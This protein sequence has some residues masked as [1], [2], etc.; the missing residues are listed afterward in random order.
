[1]S[2][3]KFTCLSLV[4][5]LASIQGRVFAWGST[6][7]GAGLEAMVSAARWKAG[8]FRYTGAF[9]LG[10]A[11]YDSDIYF[12][13]LANPIPDYT[14][15]AGPDIQILL[16]LEKKIVFAI[17]ES[18]R[19]V[20]FLDTRRERTLNNSFTGQA[21]FIF[22]RFYIQAGA[23]LTNA[24][25]RLSTELNINVRL[26]ED[27]IN[28]LALWQ[29][30][31]GTSLALQYQRSV[32]RYENTT[33]GTANISENL[34]RT[35]NYI[36]VMA[37]LQHQAKT[38]FYLDAQYGSY[39]FMEK[40]SSYKDS[41]SY[42]VYGGVEFVPPAAE[43]AS[44]TAGI[45]GR[46]NIGYQLFHVLDP[47]QNDYSGLSGNTDVSWEIIKLTSL[48]L[49]FSIGP[50]FSVYSGVT[51]YLQTLYGAGLAR[52]LSRKIM[53]SYDFSYSRNKYPA[54]EIAGGSSSGVPADRYMTHALNLNFQLQRDLGLS[55]MANLGSRN[56]RFAP[57]TDSRRYFI[58]FSL[59][60]GYSPG[61]LAM[62]SGPV[63]R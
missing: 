16:P 38:R 51:Y 15:T 14:F 35:E 12:G 48:H 23:A 55:L 26:K 21:H 47:L 8:P 19:Y 33:S 32:F 45:R 34:N 3:T 49:F 41:R 18:P 58:G 39:A 60:Y 56:S 31:E 28:G 52:S 25:Q 6:W 7:M 61:G 11:G 54:G 1:M 44:Q 13:T 9:Q 37:F 50:Q 27:S 57:R 63:S 10:N 30:S 4:V 24:K 53:L 17:S 40:I 5:L 22:D 36:D 62:P 46:I 2:R 43:Y 59:T 20:F 29:V 42:S